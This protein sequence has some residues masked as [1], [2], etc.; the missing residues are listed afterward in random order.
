MTDADL[1]RLVERA[2]ARTVVVVGGGMAGLAAAW[3]FA[4]V[5]I[6]VF[7]IERA[8][9]FGGVVSGVEIDGLPV[10]VGAESF[11][12]RGG[13]VRALIDELG[14]GDA[15]VSP[16]PRGAW[17]AGLPGGRA[18]PLPRGGVLGIPGNPWAPEVR[19]VIGWSGAWRAYLDRLRPP[20]TIGH[21]HSLGALV[22]GRMGASVL[23]RLV[24]PVTSGVYSARPDDIDV[25]VAAPGLNAALTRTGSLSG[26]VEALRGDRKTAPGGAVQGLDGGM[27]RLPRALADA[28]VERGAQ[29]RADT[30][31]TAIEA[32]GSGW[33][34]TSVS[35]GER[36]E[37]PCDAVVVAAGETTA[38]ALLA[39]V[40]ADLDA[41]G[42]ASAPVVEI[43]TLVL[44][45]PELDAPPR[46]SGVLTVPA[47]HAAKALTHS[48]AKWAWLA[49]AAGAGRHV[50]RVSF[51]AQDEAPA[52]QGRSDEDAAELALTEASALLGVSL[53]P[54]ALRAARRDRWAQ[55]QPAATI[56]RAETVAR[57]R[58]SIA[59]APGL[60][61]VGAWVS[62]AGLAQVVP[63]AQT[64][65]ERLR[66]LLL[67][68]AETA[69]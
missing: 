23:D 50:V 65:A 1:E 55:A 25:D 4:K 32:R 62:G 15:V 22:R 54:S 42:P 58:A 59:A 43:V 41:T 67:W 11:A 66:G 63:D 19:R 2:A 21:R 37:T 39:P 17:V 8:A 48:T 35:A 34:V 10:D 56:G 24:A 53:A 29:L 68:G 44:D 16:E 64:E 49:E 36:V 7:V 30:E 38:R 47:T 60:G 52:T 20:L 6:H 40:V 28:L 12:T 27:A 57:A 46:G 69:R 45:A 61:V 14:L 51:G 33:S 3:E 13:T 26:A 9:Y 31:V 5:G 18:A